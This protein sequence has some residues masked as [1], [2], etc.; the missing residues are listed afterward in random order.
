MRR[1]N[2][3]RATTALVDS[4]VNN[5]NTNSLNYTYIIHYSTVLKVESKVEA[6]NTACITT[7]YYTVCNEAGMRLIIY[8]LHASLLFNF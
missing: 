4:P 7:I 6:T 3:T 1:V 2:T 5:A 8:L